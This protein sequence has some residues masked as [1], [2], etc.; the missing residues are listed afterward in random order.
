M[1]TMI[2]FV[3]LS[4]ASLLLLTGCIT[5]VDERQASASKDDYYCVKE[6]KTGSNRVSTVCYPRNRTEVEKEVTQQAMRRLQ[7]QTQ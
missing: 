6:K 7:M 3:L 5:P 4:V 1:R 2:R